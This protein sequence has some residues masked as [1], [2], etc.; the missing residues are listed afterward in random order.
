MRM[1][2]FWAQNDSFALNKIFFGKNYHLAISP[3]HYEKFKKK[4]LTGDPE[5]WGCAIF[6]PKIVH[7]PKWEFFSENL[8]ISLAPFIQVYLRAK[9]QSQIFI[10]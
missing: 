8:L 3:F 4:T 2:Y 5:L 6:G 10:Y 9:N 1:H 7:L